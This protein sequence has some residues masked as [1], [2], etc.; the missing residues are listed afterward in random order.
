MIL[1]WIYILIKKYVTLTYLFYFTPIDTSRKHLNFI[2]KF[3][4][5]TDFK[6]A[7]AF[8]VFDGGDIY[9]D[10]SDGFG[11]LHPSYVLTTGV[12]EFAVKQMPLGCTRRVFPPVS[13]GSSRDDR[14]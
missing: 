4:F 10:G 12:S 5:K 9:E 8:A 1:S 2:K 14:S 3:L 7:V 6:Q 13:Q 11:F